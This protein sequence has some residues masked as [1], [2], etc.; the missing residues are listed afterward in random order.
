MERSFTVREKV[1]LAVLAIL[2][3]ACVYFLL[4]LQP[5]LNSISSADERVATIE[6]EIAT[7]H[8][9]AAKKASMEAEIAAAKSAG[10]VEKLLPA[11]DNSKA[12]L[13]ELDSMLAQ[14]KSYDISF[15][16]AD[17]SADPVRRSV[18]I[19]FTTNSF[20]DAYSTLKRLVNCRF[21]CV[22]TDISVTGSADGSAAGGVRA[23]ATVVFFETLS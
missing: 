9:M 4:V 3:V 2:A 17:T 19:S 10:K 22:V 6:S 7:Q 15:A 13:R 5:A 21:S 1:L 20:K 14:T 16:T 23:T 8:A 12:A 18:G 11:Y